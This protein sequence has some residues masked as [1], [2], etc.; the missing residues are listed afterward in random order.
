MVD[1]G[2]ASVTL[3]VEATLTGSL[4]VGKASAGVLGVKDIIL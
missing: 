2:A 3:T 4:L 1:P